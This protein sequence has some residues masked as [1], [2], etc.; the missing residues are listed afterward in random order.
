MKLKGTKT[1]KNL[2]TAFAGE[3]QA[4]NKYSFYAKKAKEEGYRQI[5]AIFKETAKNEKS[6]AKMWFQFLKGGDIPSTLENLTDA[7]AGE[8]Y[9]WT[10]MYANF[11]KDAKEEGFKDIAFLFE[12]VAQIEK[13]HEERY[14]KLFANIEN[15]KVFEKDAPVIWQCRHCGFSFEGTKAPETCPVCKYK[16]AF[17]EVKK[18]NY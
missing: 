10:D 3:S 2:M 18:I 6:H 14:K 17:F 13:E 11:A 7:A 1:E 15:N 8:H 4:R 12:K 16:K 9:E 5:A